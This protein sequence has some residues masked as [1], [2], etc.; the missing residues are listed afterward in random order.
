VRKVKK[1]KGELL[2]I[3]EEVLA[4]ARRLG[5][6]GD[7]DLVAQWLRTLVGSS[8]PAAHGEFN[9]RNDVWLFRIH[10]NRILDLNLLTADDKLQSD[11]DTYR[12][13]RSQLS[14][15]KRTAET[16]TEPR[17]P[18]EDGKDDPS[19][20]RR[21]PRPDRR[22]SR[23]NHTAL[24]ISTETRSKTIQEIADWREQHLDEYIEGLADAAK[25]YSEELI[26]ADKF[27]AARLGR[28]REKLLR[29]ITTTREFMA[30]WPI[31]DQDIADWV[32]QEKWLKLFG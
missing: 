8:V 25:R 30:D 11:T 18:R 14:R 6:Y 10:D 2:R 17:A 12:Q 7:S 24:R 23:R 20:T 27:H 19:V 5:M 26:R 21:D 9:F 4:K 32:E 28:R 1:S 22:R 31:T 15:D 3:S 16:S 29:Y 13:T